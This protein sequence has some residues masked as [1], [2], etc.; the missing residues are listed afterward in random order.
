MNASFDPLRI[1]NTYGAFG[2]VTRERNEV[3]IE[4]AGD[5]GLTN[6]R[7]YEFKG[8]PT[9]PKR[10]PPQWAPYHLRLDW[11]MWFAGLSRMWAYPWLPLFMMKLLENDP[12]TLKLIRRNPF[13]G[14]PP[15][16][17]RAVLYRYR[18]S[19]WKER[20]E[21]GAWWKRTRLGEYLPPLERANSGFSDAE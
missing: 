9:D 15:R 18:Y 2:S 7:E 3:V 13:P 14:H 5:P 19:T 21:T 6:W 12:D 17:V 11:L 20:R 1:V 16:A 10:L 4:G 8:K